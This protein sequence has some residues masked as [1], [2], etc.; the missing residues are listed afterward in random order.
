M[1]FRYMTLI[2]ASIGLC[3]SATIGSAHE[4]W[5]EPLKPSYAPGERIEANL[6]VG[7]NLKGNTLI[8]APDR[9]THF[10]QLHGGEAR[11]VEGILGDRPALAVEDTKEGLSVF[12]I[13]SSFS[14]L[15]YA[16]FAK[17][18]TFAKAHGEDHAIA[19]HAER[20]LPDAPFKEAYL[21]FAKSLV[22]VGS[23][24][25]ADRE[26]GM[27]FELT[28][29]D[30]PYG[31]GDQVRFL[32]TRSGVPVPDHQVD[33]FLVAEEGS[34]AVKTLHRTDANGVVAIPLASGRT[35][36]NAVSL[37]EPPQS[38]VE[39][40]DAAWYSLWASSTYWVE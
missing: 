33:M 22:K 39:E 16:E 36:V 31:G 2:G 1:S 5:I 17:F 12:G 32:L 10:F 4:Y 35:L 19:A 29:L 21:R 38:V 23:G 13:V 7:E 27:A 3:L 18:E 9:F 24:E 37:E 26:V 20:G 34:D 30:N 11:P 40:F 14:T 8:Y 25:G 28:A 15:T 6:K